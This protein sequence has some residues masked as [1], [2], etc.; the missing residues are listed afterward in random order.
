MLITLKLQRMLLALAVVGV[1]A[2]T[3]GAGGPT[4]RITIT[5]LTAHQTFTPIVDASAKTGV[6]I[7]ELGQPAS[8]MPTL[9]EAM[10]ATEPGPF[11]KAPALRRQVRRCLPPS[12]AMSS[13]IVEST[14]LATCFRS[15]TTGATQSRR[16]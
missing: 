15:S 3:F 2:P 14:E 9:P 13:S 7:F 11:L 16:S 6:K 1:S 10:D 8:V 12:W 5:N 4:F